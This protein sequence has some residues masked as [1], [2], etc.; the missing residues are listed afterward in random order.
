MASKRGLG[1]PKKRKELKDVTELGST[2]SEPLREES[3]QST[4]LSQDERRELEELW[5]ENVALKVEIARGKTQV[6][7]FV[8]SLPHTHRKRKE[9]TGATTRTADRPSLYP[10]RGRKKKRKG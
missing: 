1:C 6:L 7:T 10:H 8:S 5:A 9:E 2:Y 3:Q 4:R